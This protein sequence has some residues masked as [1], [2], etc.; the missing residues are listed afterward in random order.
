[1]AT[2][3]TLRRSHRQRQP[4][5]QTKLISQIT[6]HTSTRVPDDLL[7]VTGH[8]HSRTSRN[9]LHLGSALLRVGNWLFDKHSFPHQEGLFADAPPRTNDHY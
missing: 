3:T 7:A 6:Q 1:M 8:Q 4:L 5:G 2:P 9:T